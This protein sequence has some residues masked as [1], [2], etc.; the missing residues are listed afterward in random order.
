MEISEG[1]KHQI[2]FRNR[3]VENKKKGWEKDK[4][5]S[6]Q[7]FFLQQMPRGKSEEQHEG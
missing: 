3:K 7:H 5:L 6:T 4:G 1:K 2:L